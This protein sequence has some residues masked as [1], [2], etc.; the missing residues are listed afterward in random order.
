MSLYN[1]REHFCQQHLTIKKNLHWGWTRI[2]LNWKFSKE[3][4]TYPTETNLKVRHGTSTT[5]TLIPTRTTGTVELSHSASSVLFLP[6]SF[7]CFLPHEP[8]KLRRHSYFL[9][10]EMDI[11]TPRL[12][13]FSVIS[14]FPTPSVSLVHQDKPPTLPIFVSYQIIV[15][16]IPPIST[17]VI[18]SRLL[19]KRVSTLFPDLRIFVHSSPFIRISGVV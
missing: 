18:F 14:V 4:D 11:L 6:S 2:I 16:L 5:P 19:T 15:H 17:V 3:N 9:P 7:Y 1:V 10:L 8:V 13:S 12:W